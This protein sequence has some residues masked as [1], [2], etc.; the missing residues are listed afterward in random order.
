MSTASKTE[1]QSAKKHGHTAAITSTPARTRAPWLSLVLTLALSMSL[2]FILAGCSNDASS[3]TDSTDSSGSA[4][5]ANP[6]VEVANPEAINKKLEINLKVPEDAEIS[7]CSVIDDSLGEVVFSLDGTVYTYRG[8]ATPSSEDISGLH[9]QFTSTG[10]ADIGG[11]ECAIEYNDDAA[12][13]CRWYDDV[14]KVTYSVSVDK[15][16]SEEL[17]T[18]IATT[19]IAEQRLM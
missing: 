2:V 4:N 13:F 5:I 15:G 7:N 19:L 3:G 8:M 14:A 16:A 12:G 6:I 10:N 18:D 11:Y 1:S 17:L 9:Y